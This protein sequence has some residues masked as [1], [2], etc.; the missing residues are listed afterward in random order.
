MIVAM[1]VIMV[2]I[3]II[4]IVLSK[5]KGAFLL[6]GYNT[7]SESQKEKYKEKELCIFM[8][9]IMYGICLGLLLIALS[10]QFKIQ[11]LVIVGLIITIG[12][13]LFSMVY[14]NTSNRFKKEIHNG[15]N[16]SSETNNTGR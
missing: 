9:K 7:M 8:S 5:G 12:L 10:E 16:D 4:A 2:P 15:Q 14:M 1:L 13:P 11:A 3:L 6:A